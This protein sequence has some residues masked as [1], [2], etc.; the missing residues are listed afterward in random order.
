MK[1]FSLYARLPESM[2]PKI[3]KAE[4]D[5]PEGNALFEELR[6]EYIARYFNDGKITFS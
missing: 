1:C 4:E 3:K 5:R 6:Q 2:W